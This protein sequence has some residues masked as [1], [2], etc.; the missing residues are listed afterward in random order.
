M[1]RRG[2]RQ[3]PG[4]NRVRARQAEQEAPDPFVLSVTWAELNDL[5]RSMEWLQ[6]L[7]DRRSGGLTSLNV[8]P[9]FDPLRSHQ[10]FRAL[11]QRMN[12]NRLTCPGR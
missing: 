6:T 1:G 10:P 3:A 7:Y 11:L 8:N 2:A 9:V 4:S 12:V 5:E